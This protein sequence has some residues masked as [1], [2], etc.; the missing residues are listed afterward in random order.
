MINLFESL[1]NVK[2]KHRGHWFDE[3]TMR[4]FNSKVYDPVYCG[5]EY[6]YFVSSEKCFTE[7]SKRLYSVRK[8]HVK[9]GDISTIGE[10]QEYKTKLQADKAAKLY[11]EKDN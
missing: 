4:Y 1:C 5:K 10:F 9:T 6:W 7:G 3:S 11:A 2:H 8:F